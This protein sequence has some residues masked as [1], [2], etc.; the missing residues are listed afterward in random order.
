M[1]KIGILDDYQAVALDMA[2]WTILQEGNEI[3]TFKDH[4]SNPDDLIDRLKEFDVIIAMRERTPFPRLV[5]EHLPNL[6]LLV[7]TG[8][9]NRSIDMV[10]AED[11]GITVSGTSG[12]SYATGELTWGLILSLL[13][14]IPTEDR[15]TRDGGWQATLGEGLRNK[16]LGVIGLGNLGS[17]VATVG[18][19][20]GMDVIAWSQN[21]TQERATQFG[22]SLV[23]KDDLLRS[24]DV[25]TIH[26]ILSQRTT[27]LVGAHELELMKPTS[28]LINTSR[29]P[30][31]DE[32]ALI[33]VLERKA[34]AGAAMDVFDQEPLPSEHPL[35]RMENTVI[36][37]HIGYVVRESYLG[38][39]RQA[40]EDIQGYFAG[41]P[42]RELKAVEG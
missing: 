4:V 26:L 8:M 6:K 1:S 10:A 9:R 23:S 3:Q 22:V 12:Q 38:Y 30:I 37:P 32:A 11:L 15:A 16:T 39:F 7:T 33:D 20:F 34:I 17:Q 41:E 36:T 42:V 13:R 25:V 14:H 31:V 5:L 27:G 19:A 35:R 21:L 29:G 18:N 28:Y 24:A 40:V 2:D